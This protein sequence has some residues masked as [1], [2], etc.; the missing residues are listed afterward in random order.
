MLYLLILL[1]AQPSGWLVFAELS[2]FTIRLRLL[3]YGKLG[4]GYEG[5]KCGFLQPEETRVCE[6]FYNTSE[7]QIAYKVRTRPSRSTFAITQRAVFFDGMCV[8][9]PRGQALDCGE[10]REPISGLLNLFSSLTRWSL[11]MS[12]DV[13]GRDTTTAAPANLTAPPVIPSL[14]L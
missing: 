7:C 9:V 2:L 3:Q 4:H 11:H 6:N 13:W 8:H 14:L 10:H 12:C 5:G 1:S